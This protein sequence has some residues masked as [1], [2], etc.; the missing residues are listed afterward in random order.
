VE[1]VWVRG[2]KLVAGG[3]HIAAASARARF[4]K[5]VAKLM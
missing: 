4:N 1:S 2:K 5:I 3:Q